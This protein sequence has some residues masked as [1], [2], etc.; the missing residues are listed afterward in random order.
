MKH[1]A[2][3]PSYHRFHFNV[4]FQIELNLR[5]NY[6]IWIWQKLARTLRRVRPLFAIVWI[7]LQRETIRLPKSNRFVLYVRALRFKYECDAEHVLL[8]V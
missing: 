1:D 5:K 4:N 3:M 6:E 8:F 7:A 2:M